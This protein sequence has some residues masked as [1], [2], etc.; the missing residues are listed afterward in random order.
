INRHRLAYESEAPVNW[1]PEL[2]T[3]LA[4]EEVIGGLSERGGH[5]VVRKPM[6]QWMLR[7]T[8]FAERL[9]DGLDGL[10]WSKLISS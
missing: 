2:G 1:C 7:I 8:K 4:N 5:P 9:L 10:D 3:V 6:R